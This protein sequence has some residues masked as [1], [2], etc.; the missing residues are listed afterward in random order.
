MQVLLSL[1]R[2][3]PKLVS[4]RVEL[5]SLDIQ[6]AGLA[7]GQIVGLI[8]VVAILGVTAWLLIWAGVLLALVMVGLPRWGA[9]L[10]AI[11][12]NGL[13]LWWAVAHIRSRVPRLLLAAFRRHLI[14]APLPDAAPDAFA[15]TPVAADRYDETETPVAPA[16]PTASQAPADEGRRP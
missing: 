1:L 9:L 13:A 8:V 2:E 14:V 6:R 10:V 3:L 5:L 4:D 15:Q 7:L 16:S 11:A 12:I